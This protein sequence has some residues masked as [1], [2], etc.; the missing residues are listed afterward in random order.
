MCSSRC[1]S[2]SRTQ[3]VRN[4]CFKILEEKSIFL[5]VFFLVRG[6]FSVCWMLVAVVWMNKKKWIL[7]MY[8]FLYKLFN[9]LSRNGSLDSILYLLN[10]KRALGKTAILQCSLFAKS[11]HLRS[12]ILVLKSGH[13]QS[14]YFARPREKITI[15][16]Q[17]RPISRL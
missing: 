16:R 4:N 12:C 8:F 10:K 2:S 5:G 17:M 11:S 6:H 13:L 1:W 7:Y 9:S 3:H 15:A 14:A